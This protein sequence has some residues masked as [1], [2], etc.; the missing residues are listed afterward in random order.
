MDV[1]KTIITS[2]NP[3]WP[4]FCFLPLFLHKEQGMSRNVKKMNM[5]TD[6]KYTDTHTHIRNEVGFCENGLYNSLSVF[7]F[8]LL[9][10]FAQRKI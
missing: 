8:F 7:T 1:Y 10:L 9:S 2:K 6:Q 5:T 4:L 3:D